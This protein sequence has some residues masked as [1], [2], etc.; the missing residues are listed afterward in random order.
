MSK[1]KNGN[2]ISK[3][4]GLMK[5]G[6]G[7][8]FKTEDSQL[9]NATSSS[10]DRQN[11]L[12]YSGLIGIAVATVAE[13]SREQMKDS[14]ASYLENKKQNYTGLAYPEQL[15]KNYFYLDRCVAA[16]IDHINMYL[17]GLEKAPSRD[18]VNAMLNQ[19]R[20]TPSGAFEK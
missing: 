19:I 9:R 17:V 1:V 13:Q 12:E 3:I 16:M 5:R 11:M 6:L 4:S 10:E 20:L 2:F 14:A 15:E 7:L 18:N 8:T